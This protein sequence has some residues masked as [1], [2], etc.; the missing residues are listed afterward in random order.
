MTGAGAPGG[1]GIIKALLEGDVDLLVGDANPTASGRFLAPQFV[2]LPNA[3]DDSFIPFVLDVCRRNKIDV[4]F[5]LVTR[6]LFKFSE[7]KQEFAQEGIRILV[8][9][10]DSLSIANDK[11]KLYTH[12]Q[13]RGIPVPDFRITSTYDG[14]VKAVKELG[15]P[16][17]PLCVK[18]TVSN[19]SR[20]VRILQQSV[21]E[22]DLLFHHKPS[23]LFI[24]FEHLLSILRGHTFPELLISECLPGEEFTVD[25]L[26]GEG[27]AKLILPR[28]RTKM[29]G[30]IS[31]QG[32]F[33]NHAEIIAYCTEVISTLDLEGPI[34][35]QVKADEQ[36][37]FRILEINP[38]I[39][40]TSVAALG[41]GIN[42]PLLAVQDSIAPVDLSN[43]KPLWG[44]SFV[45]YYEEL[46]Y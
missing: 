45:R 5:P 37:R 22:F 44:K 43:T 34:G 4:V 13:A 16:T 8:S 28:V 36:N 12:L 10:F 9:D 30:G 41:L 39:Q 17:K 14:L 2:Q 18:P 19:G 15:Y 40:G 27:K 35:L 38:R 11:G 33:L 25:T 21:N 3:G 6:E 24:T 26:V 42:L 32:T 46:F 29:N 1:P 7:H 23:H 20:G 31:V